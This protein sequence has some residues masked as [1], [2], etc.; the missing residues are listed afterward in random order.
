MSKCSQLT[1]N[2]IHIKKNNKIKIT[3]IAL[4]V[5]LIL[6]NLFLVIMGQY[7]LEWVEQK[8]SRGIYPFIADRLSTLNEPFSIAMG[9]IVIVVLASLMLILIFLMLIYIFKKRYSRAVVFGLTL[10]LLITW[11]LFYFQLC[12]GINNYRETMEIL[13]DLG[14]TKIT[15][16]NLTATYTYLVAK[17][18]EAKIEAM[19]SSAELSLENILLTAYKG[20]ENLG[21]NYPFISTSKVR[22]K[23]LLISPLFS[24]SGYTGI[25]LYF[26]GEPTINSM[27]PLFSL[28]YVACHEIAHQKGFSSENDA[29]FIGFLACL[30]HEN[31]WFKYSGY[32]AAMTYVGNSL[33]N[34]NKETYMELSKA[35]SK[36]V[37]D[38]L[39]MEQKFWSSHIVE[40]NQ[41]I[42]NTINDSFLKANNQPEGIVSYSRVTELLVKAYLKEVY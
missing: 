35:R 23:P 19:N 41:E 34:T 21:K 16:E 28:G 38:D 39:I 7:H 11:N 4:S 32:E 1:E 5:I 15:E 37:V 31:P 6:L 17:T 12:F 33:Y 40:K 14:D 29:N 8:I 22:V 18:N 3:L 26:V 30:N 2:I 13:F 10:V 42:H 27:P 36:A 24:S 9:E 20:Y 25:Y